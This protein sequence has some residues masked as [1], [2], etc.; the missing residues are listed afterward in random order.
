[1]QDSPCEVCK[2]WLPEVREALEKA[3]Q[4]KRKC[5][6]A[7]AARVAKKSQEM[8][9]AIELH[10][11]EEGIH[12]PAAKRRDDGSS[13]TK[14]RA[15]SASSSKAAEAKSADRPS[16][17]H[18]SSSKATE[19]E[20][21]DQLSRSREKRKKTLLSSVSVVGSS[22]SD[23]GP[24]PS[25]TNSSEHHGSRN[26][27][28][29]RRGHGSDTRHNSPRSS[30]SSRCRRSGEWSRP[31]SSGGSSS[32]ARHTDLT[33]A[34]GSGRASG[35]TTEVWPSS[36]AT[37]QRHHSRS[38]PDRR[39]RSGSRHHDRRDNVDSGR[40]GSSYVSR[41]EVQLSPAVPQKTEKRTITVIPSPP[42]PA[43]T[44]DS[45]GVTGPADWA[46]LADS[47]ALDDSAGVTGPADSA[48]ADDSAGYESAGGLGSEVDE[49]EI[50]YDSATVADSAQH[51]DPAAADSA[52]PQNSAGDDSALPQDPAG[53][54]STQPQVSARDN[55]A[56]DD[57]PA[58]QGTPAGNAT[59]DRQDASIVSDV[60][61]LIF[62]SMPRRINQETLLDFMSMWTLM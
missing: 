24:V 45:A 39:S 25:G 43:H 41:R 60:S 62:P 16:K 3:A 21:A 5:K 53:D 12:V 15:E 10:A 9:D 22:R 56:R 17:S 13:K 11:P 19:A 50:V 55:S 4:Q 18:D 34:P 36:S 44:A 52:R 29:D 33:D 37:H 23:G 1:M 20:S 6:A 28:R 61:S 58:A 54:D 2:D 47:A 32:R 14:K 42:R 51:Q 31:T 35:R 8:D 38:S 48:E 40:S 30:H 59:V 7:T 49:P 26:D 57:R 46:A 27:D